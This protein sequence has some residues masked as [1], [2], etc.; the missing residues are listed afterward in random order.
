MMVVEVKRGS[1]GLRE[2]GIGHRNMGVA[3]SLMGFHRLELQGS[4]ML[5]NIPEEQLV[6]KIDRV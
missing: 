2:P 3:S 1:D 5:L 6:S 4:P